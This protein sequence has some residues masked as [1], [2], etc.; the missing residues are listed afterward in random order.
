MT[1]LSLETFLGVL[2]TFITLLL[3]LECKSSLF[4]LLKAHTVLNI[5]L[6]KT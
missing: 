4:G 6:R 3:K 5:Y 1:T 2:L